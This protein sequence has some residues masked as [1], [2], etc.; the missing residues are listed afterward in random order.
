MLR[1]ASNTFVSALPKRDTTQF[2]PL[3]WSPTRGTNSL[4]FG[5]LWYKLVNFW[6]YVV[7]IR[8]QAPDL[9]GREFQF[10]NVLAVKFTPQMIFPGNVKAF[11]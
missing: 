8:V 3:A 2:P 7:H 6:C 11:L 10:K 4:I 9:I 5:V 1:G